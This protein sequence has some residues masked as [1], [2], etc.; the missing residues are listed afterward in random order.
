MQHSSRASAL[1][2]MTTNEMIDRTLRIYRANLIPIITLTAVVMV[3]LVLI[4]T[5]LSAR[6]LAELSQAMLVL[7]TTVSAQMDSG[8]LGTAGAT[9]LASIGGAIL[10]GV[11]INGV[12]TRVAS[13]NHLGHNITI[14]EAFRAIQGRLALVAGALALIYLLLI[15]L[16]V[17]L[18]FVFF[19]CGL[20]VGVLVYFGVGLYAFIIPIITLEGV[21]L[22]TAF[23]RA[24]WL[25]RARFWPA[26]LLIG[27][28]GGGGLV[29]NL[30]LTS[31]QGLFVSPSIAAATA[32]QSS[33]I[34]VVLLQTTISV[35]ITPLVP[36]GLTILYYDTRV[37]FE[38]LD[39][40]MRDAAGADPR[41][42][43]VHSPIHP[44]PFMTGRDLSNLV[45]ASFAA[46]ATLFA[47]FM[48]LSLFLGPA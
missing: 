40:A 20:G 46:L 35:M 15:A 9:L 7:D 22:G 12:L 6:Y 4:N 29:L 41:P 27:G 1:S 24:W 47:V 19:L 32:I 14:M 21:D 13:E 44:G 8:L 26:A 37:R 42:A 3:P 23:Q 31:M 43:D 16:S 33:D 39:R 25:G 17:G 10:Q 36:I 45:G 38:D 28:L 2:P 11:L 48:L 34:I 30:I 18:A 5:I